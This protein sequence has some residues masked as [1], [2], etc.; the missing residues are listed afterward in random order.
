MAGSPVAGRLSPSAASALPM[1]D[2]T[3]HLVGD[4]TVARLVDGRFL[5]TGSYHLQDWHMRWFRR[6]CPRRAS[7]CATA[8]TS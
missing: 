7:S 8:P 6:T 3:G 5:I 4:L 2:E 1:L